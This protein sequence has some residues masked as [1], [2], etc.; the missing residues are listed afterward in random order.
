MQLLEHTTGAALSD[1]TSGTRVIINL[2]QFNM[3]VLLTPFC[4]GEKHNFLPLN[5]VLT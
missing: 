4:L 5:D 3:R 1:H 2:V